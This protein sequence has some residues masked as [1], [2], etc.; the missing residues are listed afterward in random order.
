MEIRCEKCN[1]LL[2]VVKNGVKIELEIKCNRCKHISKIEIEN[3]K[4]ED[5]KNKSS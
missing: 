2:T 3:A 1:K 5:N 4:A